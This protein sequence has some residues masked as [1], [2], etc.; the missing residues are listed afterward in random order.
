MRFT[1]LIACVFIGACGSSAPPVSPDNA[2]TAAPAAELAVQ[3]ISK[4]GDKGAF[5]LE[6]AGPH[7]GA[8]ADAARD[9]RV[10]LALE[11][12]RGFSFAA[13]ALLAGDSVFRPERSEVVYARATRGT[14]RNPGLLRLEGRLAADA[15][16]ARVEPIADPKMAVE[17]LGS[18]ASDDRRLLLGRGVTNIMSMTAAADGGFGEYD[19]HAWTA[20]VDAG[21]AKVAWA[22]QIDDAVR[23]ADIAP[24][25]PYHLIVRRWRPG[26]TVR[27]RF[28]RVAL[29]DV[30]IAAHMKLTPT[31]SGF[32]WVWEGVWAGDFAVAPAPVRPP[33]WPGAPT[34]RVRYREYTP[35][36]R[37]QRSSFISTLLSP[38]ALGGDIG[39]SLFEET[40]DDSDDGMGTYERVR[41]KRSK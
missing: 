8:L 20:V 15:G 36:P 6:L 41:D 40:F 7:R 34:I 28:F 3:R 24:L 23:R 13:F 14:R 33:A 1:W 12:P 4:D 5:A 18:Y 17:G 38:I 21:G 10:W 30:V 32:D 25:A 16:A 2:S 26:A 29:A 39:A 11:R 35:A 22:A 27:A 31:R 9:G 37:R 19:T